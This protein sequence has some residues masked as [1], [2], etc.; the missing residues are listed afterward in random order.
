VA[1]HP[2]D[3]T[4]TADLAAASNEQT[5]TTNGATTTF[6]HATA[7]DLGLSGILGVRAIG[8]MKAASSGNDAL[9]IGSTEY[10]VAVSTT[11]ATNAAHIATDHNAYTDAAFNAME[12]GARNKR[13]VSLQLGMLMLEVLHTGTGTSLEPPASYRHKVVTYTG[14]G[15]WQ[16]IDCGFSPQVV[17]V[18]KLGTTPT[19]SGALWTAHMGGTRSRMMDVAD[20]DVSQGIQGATATGFKVG[21]HTFVNA[22]GATYVALCIADGGEH[23]DGKF[24]DFGMFYGTGV[25]N[26]DIVIDAAGWQPS[27]LWVLGTGLIYRDA[28][29]VG[30]ASWHLGT[31]LT[32]AN[33]IQALNSDGFEVGISTINSLRSRNYW[34]AIK[35]DLV[36]TPA[37]FAKG[38]IATPGNPYTHTGLAFAPHL[39]VAGR[40]G[41]SGHRFRHATAHSGTNST[42][43]VG[44]ATVTTG[45]TALTS[46]GWSGALDVVAGLGDTYFFAFGEEGEVVIDTGTPPEVEF[47]YSVGDVG[48]SWREIYGIE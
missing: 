14:D 34:F 24:M 44:G 20:A 16:T 47:G 36:E 15:S 4:S 5:V 31:N 39:V 27:A 21:P 12:F 45:I 46:D 35:E 25:D 19:T 17:I 3:R 13:G 41:T 11:Y 28:N 29:F 6:A 2:L 32:V 38:K 48:L 10:T 23:D 1:E 8:Y 40:T 22:S 33:Q 43:W 30:D 42:P 7:A 9:L 37:L 26:R 18:K